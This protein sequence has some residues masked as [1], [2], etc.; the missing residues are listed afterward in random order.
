[1]TDLIFASGNEHKAKELREI[2]GERFS[3]T[4]LNEAGL[5]IDIPEPYD[6]LE[7]NASEKSRIIFEL[8]QKDCFGEDTGLEVLALGGKPGVKSARYAGEIQDPVKNTEKLL[9]EMNGVT[10]RTARF[11]TIISFRTNEAN[12]LFEGICEGIIAIS[13]RGGNGF[14]YDSVFIPM[15]S[16]ETFGEMTM[17][18]KGLFSHRK[19]AC[20]KLV[21]FL[22]HRGNQH[23]GS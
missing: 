14:G 9:M 23:W 1:M 6:T 10:N 22:Q 21:L 7:E 3:F 18:Q 17:A 2:V 13:P 15:G 4:T 11:R 19:K 5:K 16:E 20:D 12:L 8:T